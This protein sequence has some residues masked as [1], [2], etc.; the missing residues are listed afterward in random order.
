MAWNGSGT[1]T[2]TNGTNAGSTTWQDDAAA[3]TKIT[4]SN[5]DTHDEDLAT[6]INSSLTKNNETKP[7]AHFLPNA[8]A[9]YNLGSASAQWVNLFLSGDATAATFLATGDTSAGDN[10]A[11]GYTATEGLVLTGQGSISDVVIKNDADA[12]VITIATGGTAVDIVGDVTALTVTADGDVSA[13]DTA[14]L[15]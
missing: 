6:A 14:T 13:S 15:G 12:D 11:V 4:A 2:R 5:H 10:A 7:T 1:F 8:D 9:S 3:G